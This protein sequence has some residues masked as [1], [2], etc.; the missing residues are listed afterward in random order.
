MTGRLRTRRAFLGVAGAV[1]GGSLLAGAVA[2]SQV[3][4]LLGSDPAAGRAVRARALPGAGRRHE[5][6]PALGRRAGADR[7]R[8]RARRPTGRR[9]R[10]TAGRLQGL[11]PGT[12]YAWSA[13]GRRRRRGAR[14]L[15][16]RAGDA[17]R[18]RS[19][20]RSSATTATA[21]RTSAPSASGSSSRTRAS[22]SPRATTAT[23]WPRPPC[24]T[25][26][27]SSP[28]PSSCGARRSCS[29][30]ATTTSS[31]PAP[32]AL[33]GAFGQERRQVVRYG[34]VQLVI[35]GDRVT[36]DAGLAFVRDALAEPG[37]TVRFVVQH[38]PLQ[39]GNPLAAVARDGGANAVFV[40][41]LHRYERR[42]VDGMLQFTVGSSGK[43]PGSLEATPRSRD[44]AVSLLD[45]GH[46]RVDLQPGGGDRLPLRGRDRTRAGRARGVARRAAVRF[47]AWLDGRAV[48]DDVPRG[49]RPAAR[50]AA[51]TTGAA[52][53]AFRW[54]ELE[55]F[56]W[57]LDFLDVVPPAR[58]PR[59]GHRGRR[60]RAPTRAPSASSR[61][62]SEPH[63]ELAARP[64]RRRAA[65]ACW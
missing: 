62:R 10:R 26:T 18:R 59:A 5:R 12:R 14:Q 30:W 57:A 3:E 43:G 49:A 42:V 60:R 61:E 47:A 13:R 39:P 54:P 16:H 11:A 50:R 40:G 29:A 25:A 20:S 58:A 1:V 8:R 51:A 63:R 32:D 21:A 17:R 15:H 52:R 35:C 46:L 22:S 65:T 53:G 24:S 2:W 6:G 45:Y 44:A 9:S 27:S 34:P 64:R 19:R 41:H 7:R 23:S 48:D 36:D 56:N 28:S 33:L 4:R 31:G 37:P 38:R 55:T